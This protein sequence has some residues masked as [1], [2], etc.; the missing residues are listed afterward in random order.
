MIEEAD[1]ILYK[2]SIPTES[3]PGHDLEKCLTA[4]GWLGQ[5]NRIY[6]AFPL[7]SGFIIEYDSTL[8]LLSTEALRCTSQP[9]VPSS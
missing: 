4:P 7:R 5:A 6:T 2:D 8:C 3:D 9:H 1:P